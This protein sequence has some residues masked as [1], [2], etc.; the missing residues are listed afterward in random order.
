VSLEHCLKIPQNKILSWKYNST[1]Y[2]TTLFLRGGCY[3]IAYQ[4]NQ[5]WRLVVSSLLRLG[6]V[7]PHRRRS[8]YASI[9][10][11]VH[12]PL[13]VGASLDR[14]WWCGHTGYSRS[15]LPIYLLHRWSESGKIF[16]AHM[17]STLLDLVKW[18]K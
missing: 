4:Q 17:A 13:I 9:V 7:W 18:K 16:T 10:P 3:V 2:K 1:T 5:N 11:N 8:T 12:L 14:F 6:C 15:L